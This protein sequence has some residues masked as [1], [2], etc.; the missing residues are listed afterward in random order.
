MKNKLLVILFAATV[1]FSCHKNAPDSVLQDFFEENVL[2]QTFVVSYANNAGEDITT[3]YQGYKFVLKKGDYY[4][5]PLIATNGA[6]QYTGTWSSNSDYSQL[7]ISLPQPPNEFKFLS[8]KWRF[9]SK[10]LPVLKLA[11]WVDTGFKVELNMT[12]Q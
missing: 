5:G 3:A 12:R 9:T 6:T 10:A 4:K 11:L 1:N 2:N 8:N 7:I